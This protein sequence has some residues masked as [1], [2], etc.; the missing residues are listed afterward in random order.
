[1]L[2]TGVSVT[3][4]NDQNDSDNPLENDSPYS[5]DKAHYT[6]SEANALYDSY[7]MLRDYG[8]EAEDLIPLMFA[9]EKLTIY[10]A[11]DPEALRLRQKYESV[12]FKD[13]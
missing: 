9:I 13:E 8:F 11:T 5:Y 2:G 1:L 12:V 3:N 6:D 4:M 7:L 10:G